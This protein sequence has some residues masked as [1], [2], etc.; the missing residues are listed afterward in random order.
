[1][2][3]TCD[4]DNNCIHG[5]LCKFRDTMVGYKEF[6]TEELPD[7]PII[8]CNGVHISCSRY[9][10]HITSKEKMSYITI[11]NQRGTK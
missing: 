11:A 1:M 6:L 5:V 10:R 9:S 3:I 4:C 7:E 8:V 2:Q